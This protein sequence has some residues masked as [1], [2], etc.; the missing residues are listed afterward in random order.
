MDA[1]QPDAGTSAGIAREARRPRAVIACGTGRYADPWHPYPET[2][3]A[4]AELLRADD[5]QVDVVENPDEALAALDGAA[6]LVVNA[7]D[8]WRNGE[9]ARGADP[10]AEAGLT[11]AF[12]RGIGVI[13]THSALSSLRDYPAFRR[14]IGGEWEAGRSWH[15]EIDDAAVRVVDD[16]HGIARA[17]FTVF[18]ERYTDLVVD[19]GATVLAVHDLDG[20]AHPVVWVRETSPGTAPVRALVSALGHDARA[21]ESE[22][23]RAVLTRGARWAARIDA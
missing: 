9:A 16:A 17:D 19:D 3:A 2:S 11:A 22:E 15:P 20:V 8:P 4:I 14:A 1:E 13:A 23:L 12:G 6:L 10:D 18:D 7:G 21:Y 5:W